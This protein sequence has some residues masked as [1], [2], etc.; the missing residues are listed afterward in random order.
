VSI[1]L[2]PFDLLIVLA[3]YCSSLEFD[4]TLS[5]ISSV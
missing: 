2:G 5:V 1:V 3:Q 4:L